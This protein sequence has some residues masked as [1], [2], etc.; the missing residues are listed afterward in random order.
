MINYFLHLKIICS[1][2]KSVL[3]NFIFPCSITDILLLYLFYHTKEEDYIISMN[4]I[5][6]EII[7]LHYLYRD[8]TYGKY[9]FFKSDIVERI[10][11]KYKKVLC[12]CDIISANTG[13]LVDVTELFYLVENNPDLHI[14]LICTDYPGYVPVPHKQLTYLIDY[15]DYFNINLSSII[16][17]NRSALLE[18]SK[19]EEIILDE[20]Y[21]YNIL[22]YITYFRLNCGKMGIRIIT[23]DSFSP[24][25]V[26]KCKLSHNIDIVSNLTKFRIRK[27]EKG[28]IQFKFYWYTNKY[29]I[30]TL[31]K[32]IIQHSK[33]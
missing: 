4:M 27:L 26:I 25:Q 28:W 8:R 1:E 24:L 22:Q 18:S 30:D 16:T 23:M 3:M 7:L 6:N 20:V 5:L 14:C 17:L 31:F 12:F 15:R 11:K 19:H 13:N 2:N 9:N 21:I 29:C 10:C 33:L 32:Y